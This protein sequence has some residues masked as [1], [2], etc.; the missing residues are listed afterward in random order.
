MADLEKGHKYR[1]TGG[2]E[3]TPIEQVN[4]LYRKINESLVLDGD[5][6]EA[7]TRDKHEIISELMSDS[8]EFVE[9]G[10]R[11]RPHYVPEE[12]SKSYFGQKKM[13]GGN[14]K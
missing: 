2:I 14:M 12:Q 10:V 11:L 4:R 8:S 7:I 9:L 3:E 5:S 6:L 1:R 13:I